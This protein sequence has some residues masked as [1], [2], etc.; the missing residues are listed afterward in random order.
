MP[1][2]NELLSTYGS[3][4][5]KNQLQKIVEIYDSD[6]IFIHELLQN[7]VDAVQ[8][9]RNIARG[10][11]QLEVDIDHDTVIVQDNGFGFQ[12]KLELL[13]PGGSGLEKNLKS[14]SSSKGY[15]G[16]GL[17]AV[18]YS[19]VYFSIESI[20]ED[21]HDGF[22]K[23]WRFSG[24]NLESYL[25]TDQ[26]IEYE[27]LIEA[28]NNEETQTKITVQ[29]PQGS[30]NRFFSGLQR[31]LSADTVKWQQLYRDQQAISA[32]KSQEAFA[33]HFI[34]WYFQTQSYAGCVNRLLNIPVKNPQTDHFEEVKPVDITL[35]LKS[36]ALFRDVQG[37]LGTWLRSTNCTE[38]A[39]DIDNRYWDYSLVAKD[40]K[41]KSAKYRITPEICSI[42]PNSPH[43]LKPGDTGWEAFS[44]G[45]RDSFLDL[46]LVPDDS[47][48]DFR[49]KYADII[50]LLER[51]GS[52]VRAEN[53]KD[54]IE[55]ITGIYFCI[56]RT[57]HYEQ[58]GIQNRGERI[59]ASNGTPT[60]HNLSIRSTSSTWYAETITFVVNVDAN[61]N[62]G[63]RNLTD[64]RL[65]GRIN[66]FFEACYPKLVALSKLFVER[67]SSSQEI[68]LPD[69]LIQR[70]ISRENVIFKRFPAD[71][72]TLIGLFSVCISRIHPDFSVYGY[73]GKAVYDGKFLWDNR[74][75]GSEK[76]LQ[77]L[78][79]K[80]KLSELVQ[81]F[82]L[83][84][85]DKDIDSVDLIVV[86]DRQID[87]PGWSVKGVSASRE[88]DLARKQIPTSLISYILEDSRGHYRPL[89]C[90][91]DLVAQLPIADANAD[92]VDQLLREMN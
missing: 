80:V 42:K 23:K 29:F 86:W 85:N 15:Q 35:I 58:L 72:D 68:E 47:K 82:E 54:V 63:K 13:V 41:S 3:H 43:W 16:V 44:A 55:K 62:L 92:D 76:E 34:R 37:N 25:H 8:F 1:S 90:V 18:M 27:T 20:Y 38:L 56:G 78:E 40:N 87:I 52:S 31:F 30:A 36:E 84:T 74:K 32:E 11:V 77:I 48:T 71:E 79:F 5:V 50:A 46:K 66:S 53:F 49:E 33:A 4:I 64:N 6:W 21:K 14:R 45:L 9:N 60:A 28:A 24:A 19:S 67:P 7:A 2:I 17:K 81:E 26:E 91:A 69:I 88:V 59:I 75:I 89:I 51:R 57:A 39:I 22:N 10:R 70:G 83:A 65:V 61:L 73:F 12:P